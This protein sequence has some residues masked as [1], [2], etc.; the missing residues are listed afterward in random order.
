MATNA[1][2]EDTAL[3]SVFGAFDQDDAD[4]GRESAAEAGAS[5]RARRIV[6]PNSIEPGDDGLTLEEDFDPLAQPETDGGIDIDALDEDARAELQANEGFIPHIGDPNADHTPKQVVDDRPADVRTAEL[7]ERMRP[8]RR[9]LLGILRLCAEPTDVDV[10][11]AS[12]DN[13][14]AHHRSVYSGEALCSLL[15]RAGALERI[16]PERQEPKVVTDE[17]GVEYLEPA[18]QMSVQ[19]HTLPAGQAMVDADMPDDRLSQALEKE[20][21]YKP[22]YLAI[23]KACSEEGGKT[24]KQLGD[25]V[26]HDPLL[27]HPRRWAPYFFGILGECDALAWDTTWTITE[28]GRRGIEQLEA[29]GISA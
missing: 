1:D 11:Y 14:Q 9:E 22:I 8:R 4:S 25:L 12:V 27:Q 15:V 26:D 17:N 23:L 28:V 21:Q 6:N 24:A 7:F 16:E 3:N 18:E 10:V 5:A 2:R 19:Y 20:P 29:E 13:A